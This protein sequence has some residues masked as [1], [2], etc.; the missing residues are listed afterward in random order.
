MAPQRFELTPEVSPQ[1][2]VHVDDDRKTAHA[3]EDL[4]EIGITMKPHGGIVVTLSLDEL[5][6]LR[7][8]LTRVID[9]PVD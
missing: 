5:V 7:D 8:A 1:T 4:I 2:T 3:D 6:E 9:R